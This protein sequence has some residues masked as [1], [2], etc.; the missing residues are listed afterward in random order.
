MSEKK[1]EEQMPDLE[2]DATLQAGNQDGEAGQINGESSSETQDAPLDAPLDAPE[3]ERDIDPITALT[4]ERD[5]LK[6]QLLRAM[7]EMEN[8]RRRAERDVAQ[9]RQYGHLNFARDLLSSFDNLSAA[10]SAAPKMD[11]DEAANLDDGVK[12]LLIGI[13]MIAREIE[14]VLERHHITRINPQGEKFDYNLH[15]AMFEIESGEAEPGTVL[16]V[17]QPGYQL[18]DRLLRPAMVGVAKAPAKE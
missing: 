3:D 7:A 18:R 5:D 15:Q 14:S 17:A 1:T 12:N 16:Q 6:D 2:K 11:G 10:L 4:A 9:S 8:I 13:E